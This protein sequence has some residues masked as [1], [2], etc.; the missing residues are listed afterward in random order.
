MKRL[1]LLAAL[2]V[3]ISASGQTLLPISGYCNQGGVSAVT[4]GQSSQNFLQGVVPS[5]TVTVFASGTQNKVTI[6]ANA[7]GATLGN[8]FTANNAGSSNPGFWVFYVPIDSLVDVQLSG[9]ISPN[10][11]K[12]PVVIPGGAPGSGGISGSAT[13][14]TYAIG[15]GAASIGPGYISE[16]SGDTTF[17]HPMIE[18]EHLAFGANATLNGGA[19]SVPASG[20]N[21]FTPTTVETLQEASTA[22]DGVNGLYVE[23]DYSPATTPDD[24]ST[25][26]AGFFNLQVDQDN[27]T[28]SS[29]PVSSPQ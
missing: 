10:L 8:P 14:G 9:G 17:A 7:Q 4:S 28:G 23:S 20:Q 15:T 3:C 6:Y 2:L 26:Y 22:A 11:Y 12:S 24:S 1:I 25:P 5:C 18:P 27:A 29:P 13:S 19:T 21:V 16:S